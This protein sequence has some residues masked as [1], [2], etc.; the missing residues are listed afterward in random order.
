MRAFATSPD[1]TPIAY[2][3]LGTGAPAL[4]FVHGWSCDRGYWDGQLTP[5]SASATVVALDLAGHG[6]SELSRFMSEIEV[7]ERMA[8]FRAD[9]ADA[10]KA[11]ARAMFPATA[12]PLLVERICADMSSAPPHVA[13]DALEATWNHGRNNACLV[14]VVGAWVGDGGGDA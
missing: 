2:E 8:P 10:A 12:D 13:L 7:Q 3:V 6:E 9:F 11:F 5:L 1:G 14:R 4:V